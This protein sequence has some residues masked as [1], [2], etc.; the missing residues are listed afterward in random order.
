MV[1]CLVQPIRAQNKNVA[2]PYIKLNDFKVQA[3]T[4]ANRSGKRMSTWV[5]CRLPR[6][7]VFVSN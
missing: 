6:T 7:H 2:T 5:L 3:I 4:A 1:N